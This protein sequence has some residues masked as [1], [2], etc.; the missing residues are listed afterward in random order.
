MDSRDTIFKNLEKFKNN[1]QLTIKT[2]ESDY[3]DI[4]KTFIE[5]ATL[6]G[7]QVYSN[8]EEID[9]FE[10]QIIKNSFKYVSTLGV[11][12]NGALWCADL[13]DERHKLFSCD[14]LIIEIET[15][16][17]V[18]NMHKAYEKI[19]LKNHTFS[20]F[21][22]GPSKTADIEQSLVIGAHGAMQLHILLIN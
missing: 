22:A 16:N 14:N 20:T 19:T 8:N 10:A 3:E 21:I 12:E 7:A 18:S 15:K 5:N 4:I 13:K 11:A 6:A 17:I 9:N 1:T 2:F